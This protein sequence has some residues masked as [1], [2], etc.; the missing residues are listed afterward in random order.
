MR[1]VQEILREA[2]SVTVLTGAGVSA[3][4]SIP[5]FRADG[6]LWKHFRAEDLATPEAF[7]RDPKLVWDWYDRRRQ[8][9]AR[10]QPNP[11]H[12]A[13]AELESRVP[14]FTLITQNVDDL[15]ERAGSRR[16]LKLHGDIWKV[17]CVGC[18]REQ[19]DQRA[20]L[21]EVPPLCECGE[22]LRP[23]V[24]WFGEAL[25]Q[26]V[27]LQAEQAVR[28]AQVLLV[29]GTSAI[30]YPAAGLVQFAKMSGAKIIEINVTAS[31]IS[32]GAD[33]FLQGASGELLPQLIA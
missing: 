29:V 20:P 28:S 32:D 23:G 1:E 33:A 25:P 22:L 15:H 12:Y 10:A 14:R 27:W 26:D 8:M 6:G 13:L 9:I 5:T 7:G 17:R 19:L 30:V 2:F 21:P 4:S 18:G 11:G 16:I 31:A 3:E 24:V